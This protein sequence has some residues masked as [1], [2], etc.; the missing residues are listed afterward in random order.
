MRGSRLLPIGS[1]GLLLIVSFVV[2]HCTQPVSAVV[3]ERDAVYSATGVD[4]DG[5]RIEYETKLRVPLEQ[6]EEVW[7]WLELRYADTLWLNQEG[8][9]FQ[10]TFGDEDFTDMYFDTPDLQM[11]TAE[12]G[13]RHR[14]RVVHSGPA[15]DKAG[16]QLLQIKLDHGDVTGVARAEIKFEVPPRGNGSSLDDAHPMLSLV[17]QSQRE[18]FYAVFRAM[19]ID[20]YTMRPVLTLQQNRRRIYLDDQIG[21][22]ATLTL[23]LCSTNSWGTDLRWAEAELELNE[24]RYTEAGEA[25]RQ[26]MER[27]IETIQSDLQQTFP[28]I[29]QDQ[30][31]KYNTAFAA[32]EAATW[33]PVRRL[34]QWRM[35]AVDFIAVVLV[36][37][38]TMCGAIWYGGRRW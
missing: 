24:I 37:L 29:V 14:K 3:T 36:S 27:V 23:D 33:L 21:A 20:A 7:Q 32:I 4:D 30:T 5:V 8:Y 11:L 25:E 13:V 1:V 17:H 9:V 16:R 35:D 26:R 34:I 31:P 18:E 12:G 38:V 6:I 15:V 22:F 19:G 2:F 28:A 10:A